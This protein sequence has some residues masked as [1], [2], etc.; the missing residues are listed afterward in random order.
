M[1]YATSNTIIVEKITE[2]FD[3]VNGGAYSDP[4]AKINDIIRIG[5]LITLS[6]N[7][8]IKVTDVKVLTNQYATIYCEGDIN[9]SGNS[10]NQQLISVIHNF[11]AN[12]ISFEYQL[13]YDSAVNSDVLTLVTEN[14]DIIYFPNHGIVPSITTDYASA[15][16]TESTF[17]MTKALSDDINTT[18]LLAFSTTRSLEDG[19]DYSE[20]GFILSWDTQDYASNTY[21]A[22]TYIGSTIATF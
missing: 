21:F 4:N 1:G 17:A 20:D 3:F 16:D 9:P 19:S 6:N 18:E 15:E 12:N 10:I 8:Y 22:E 13:N 14:N 5:D 2:V 7:I 11:D